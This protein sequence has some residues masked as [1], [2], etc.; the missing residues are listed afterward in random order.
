MKSRGKL[1]DTELRAA[2]SDPKVQE[3]VKQINSSLDFQDKSFDG[4]FHKDL[5]AIGITSSDISHAHELDEFEL[6][7]AVDSWLVSTSL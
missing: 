5:R 4:L 3:Q 7:N 2:L 6:K 1:D